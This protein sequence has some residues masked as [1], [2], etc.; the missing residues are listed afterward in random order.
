MQAQLY[1]VPC[2]ITTHWLWFLICLLE[3]I[4]VHCRY[5]FPFSPAKF[6]P[7]YGGAEYRD[8]HHYIGG[9]GS[10]NF[11]SVF[12]YRDY[13]YGSNKGSTGTTRQALQ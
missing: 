7:F 10:S 3:A 2:H 1:I 4:E 13:I 5:D 9:R 8:Y 11:A 12:T 6:I